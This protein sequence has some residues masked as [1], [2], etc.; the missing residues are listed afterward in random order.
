MKN[1]LKNSLIILFI[2]L[3]T[4]CNS[5]QL[6]ELW[7]TCLSGSEWDQG[8]SII[9]NN[10]GFL[11]YGSTESHDGDIQGHHGLSDAW[12][13]Q[14]D[15][16][17]NLIWSTCYGGSKGEYGE[18]ILKATDN[19]YYLTGLGGSE[20]GDISYDP[21][22]NSMDYWIVKVDSYGEIIW[23]RI[24]GGTG[25]DWT[26]NAI[27]TNDEGI[28]VLGLTTSNDGD[29]SNYS[30]GWDLW[31]VKL[32]NNGQ[33]QWDLSLG[34]I[35][36]EEG[37]SVKQTSD[38]GYIVVGDT[39]GRGGGNYDTTCNHHNIGFMDTWV[40]KL[41]S[42]R[43]IEWQ[44]CYGGFYH[45]GGANILELEDGYIVLSSTMSND[46]DVTG[47]HG[48][49]GSGDSGSDIWVFKIDFAGNLIWQKCLGGSSND[50]ARNIF[51]TSDGGFMVVGRTGSN[52]GDV[53]GYQGIGTGIY[54]DVWMV[55]LTADGELTWQYCYG[56]GG[57]ELMYR[58][59]IQKSDYNYVM[60]IGTDTDEWQCNGIMWPSLRIFELGDSTTTW[61]NQYSFTWAIDV[62]PNPASNKIIFSYS[63]PNSI[64]VG[65]LI[66]YNSSGIL[67]D[68]LKLE[69][70][71]GD[72]QYKCSHLKPGVYFYSISCSNSHKTGKFVIVR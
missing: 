6:S 35:G 11:V 26:R 60:T 14:V 24:L 4:N 69:N 50:N 66:L 10:Q 20:N 72:L 67:I 58:G 65:E 42:L 49:P 51:I 19:E 61:I 39:D 70:D 40:V 15:S 33:K 54:E 46:G 21:Y 7:H 59:V 3:V 29:I 22:P 2:T 25:I 1:L 36:G 41:D 53:V 28:L 52:D 43:N 55:K 27:V 30:G 16:V 47:F 34:G 44:Q 8:N 23:D 37:A 32:N 62:F 38:G 17:G 71:Y 64:E 57:R 9:E 12:L 48:T 68:K 56:G 13:I 63:L 31:M 18:E 45:E 5:Q